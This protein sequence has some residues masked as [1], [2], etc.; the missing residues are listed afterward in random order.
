MPQDELLERIDETGTGRSERVLLYCRTDNRSARAAD[1]LQSLGYDNVA[2][3][4]GGI[5]GW[6]DAELPVIAKYA[7]QPGPADALFAPHPAA[8][9]S[10]SRAR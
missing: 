3:I 2:V 4:E 10:A 6:L 1:A 8:T 7:A 9:R 5:T